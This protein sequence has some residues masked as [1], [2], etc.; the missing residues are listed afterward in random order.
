LLKILFSIFS[1]FILFCSFIVYCNFCALIEKTAVVTNPQKLSIE[2][3]KRAFAKFTCTATSD[4]ST[5]V[6]IHW[7]RFH[8]GVVTRIDPISFLEEGVAVDNN[9]SLI[10]RS[11]PGSVKWFEYL[12]VYQCQA[13][14][15]YSSDSSEIKL[16]ALDI[17]STRSKQEFTTS[18]ECCSNKTCI[19]PWLMI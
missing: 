17:P 3:A 11:S 14:N 12:G 2:V 7:Y 4:P 10:F 5:P 18:G 1:A 8:Q 9:H 16:I 6:I 13:N 19:L 15:G